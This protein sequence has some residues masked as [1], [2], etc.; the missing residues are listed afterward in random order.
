MTNLAECL[1]ADP[2]RFDPLE[3]SKPAK[4]QL[5]A[6]EATIRTYCAPCKIRE[7]CKRVG[8]SRNAGGIWGGELYVHVYFE[9]GTATRVGVASDV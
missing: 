7:H 5:A 6:A 1:L 3:T 2:Q 9:R 8:K 4:W